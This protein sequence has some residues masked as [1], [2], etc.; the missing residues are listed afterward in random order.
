MN[1]VI[2]SYLDPLLWLSQ[3]CSF[4]FMSFFWCYYLFYN[5]F[6]SIRKLW[7]CF[8]LSFHWLSVKLKT[9][10]RVSS[11]NLWLFSCWLGRSSWSFERCPREDIFKLIALVL[12]VNFMSG[13]SVELMYVS[14]IESISLKLIHLHGFQLIVL[15]PWFIEII[16]FVCTNR[17]NFLNLK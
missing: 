10:C 7:S 3:S 5:S 13:F 8:H 14:L 15:L 9:R 12:L 2:R 4:G 11:H 16:F 1:S 6:L 17:A